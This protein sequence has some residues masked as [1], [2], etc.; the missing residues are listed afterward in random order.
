[1]SA[2]MA[3]AGSERGRARTT[4]DTA[5]HERVSARN[6]PTALQRAPRRDSG[7]HRQEAATAG[8]R[9]PS[10]SYDSPYPPTPSPA[11]PRKHTARTARAHRLR[12]PAG[13]I[14]TWWCVPRHSVIALVSIHFLSHVFS[15]SLWVRSPFFFSQFI[16][17]LTV[18][19]QGFQYQRGVGRRI[20]SSKSRKGSVTEM[21]RRLKGLLLFPWTGEFRT[22]HTCLAALNSL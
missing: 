9:K 4:T 10:G 6:P 20:R 17:L 13:D 3:A 2:S 5:S 8:A 12:A 21:T 1:M 7:R 22:Q 19:G 14:A 15:L 11:Q 16:G 18:A